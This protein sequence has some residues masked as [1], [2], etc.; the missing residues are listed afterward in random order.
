MADT[1][2]VAGAISFVRSGQSILSSGGFGGS[3]R[4]SAVKL[5]PQLQSISPQRS[6]ITLS[7]PESQSALLVAISAGNGILNALKNLKSSARLAA[8]ESIV[9]PLTSLT[10]N[11]TR[12]SRINIDSGINLALSRI[13]RLVTNS[14]VRNGNFISSTAGNIRVGTTRFGGSVEVAP[15]PLDRVGLNL[16]GL[17]LLTQEGAEAAIAKLESAI[18]L[19]TIRIQRLESLNLA[20]GQA[21]FSGRALDNIVIGAGGGKVPSGTLVN[22]VG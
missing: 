6:K 21:D 16:T 15:Q 13:D 1:L 18:N 20:I 22:L 14:A 10:V 17:N 19:A 4:V 9:S 5:D 3:G 7:G 12:V 8:H 11:T 2:T